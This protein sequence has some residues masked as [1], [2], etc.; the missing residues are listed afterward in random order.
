[1]KDSYDKNMDVK[2]GI[3]P[4]DFNR[5]SSPSKTLAIDSR[6]E[7]LPSFRHPSEKVM[8][9][10]RRFLRYTG[11]TPDKDIYLTNLVA[12]LSRYSELPENHI[13]TFSETYRAI[14]TIIRTFVGPGDS[15][16]ICRPTDEINL[17]QGIPDN[18]RI[19]CHD[20]ITPFMTDPRGIID[21]T[22]ASTGLIYLANPNLNTGT[23]YGIDEIEAI[24][25]QTSNVKIILDE[26][27]YEYYGT[28]LAGLIRQYENLIVIRSFSAA[29]GLAD[30]PCSYIL[31]GPEN[32]AAIKRIKTKHN[33]SPPAQVV[34]AAV[35]SD[36]EYLKK[37][38]NTVRENMTY[39]SVRLRGMGIQTH[40]TPTDFLL[41]NVANP[42]QV[43]SRLK[44]EKIM[45]RDLSRMAGLRDYI[46]I[47][48]TD[49]TTSTQII[50]AFTRMPEQY[51]LCGRTGRKLVL[52]RTKETISERA[53]VKEPEH[54]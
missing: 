47:P 11:P 15:V 45:V 40:P 49:D 7:I 53:G 18:I 14:Q 9:S 51:Y 28:S 52:Q 35:L 3:S 26:T 50:E 19:T 16:L 42:V 17:A 31:A 48:V 44:A 39:L 1:M 33:A 37:H 34:A 6:Q 32:I 27:Y 41:L 54:V 43:M 46:A 21:A 12:G 36:Y 13:H 30:L 10:L 23:V 25:D 22:T 38:I 24:V 5:I 29:F 8:D 20:A 2:L 4:K